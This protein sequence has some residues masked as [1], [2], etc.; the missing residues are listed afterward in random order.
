MRENEP[1][2]TPP[3]TSFPKSTHELQRLKRE[4]L[5]SERAKLLLGCYR[6]GDAIDPEIY[7]RAIALV[8][9]YYDDWVILE[10]THPRTGIQASEKFKSWPP[11]S[12]E[13]KQFCDDMAKREARYAIYDQLPKPNLAPWQPALPRP[14]ALPQEARPTLTEL[15]SRHSDMAWA[16]NIL[17]GAR[18]ARAA[19]HR[20]FRAL[21]EIMKECGVSQEQ[22]DAIAPAKK[23]P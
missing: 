8:L 5:A 11:N 16:Q 7:I 3:T 10:A 6:R 17:S 22:V 19:P 12:G 21:S 2:S 23:S 20:G 13:L 18:T 15:A 1:S 14:P 4:R 9:A